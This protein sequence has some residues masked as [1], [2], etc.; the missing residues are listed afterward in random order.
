VVGT[1]HVGDAIDRLD[2]IGR[3]REH[4]EIT[5]RQEVA[6]GE[7]VADVSVNLP[8]GEILEDRPG[9]VKLDKLEVAAVTPRCRMVH[10]LAD[11]HAGRTVG[12]C[13]RIRPGRATE[14]TAVLMVG[15]V[16]RNWA[17]ATAFVLSLVT[18]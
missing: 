4:D 15:P 6:I 2:I 7:L 18:A 3:G 11:D 9:V 16:S 8:P 10:D 17:V 14:P 13:G 5:G 1:E 12:R